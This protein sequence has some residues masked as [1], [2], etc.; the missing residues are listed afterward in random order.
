[1]SSYRQIINDEVFLCRLNVHKER[2]KKRSFEEQN[3]EFGL[4]DVYTISGNSYLG[5][6]PLWWKSELLNHLI[7]LGEY[8]TRIHRITVSTLKPMIHRWT[9]DDYRQKRCCVEDIGNVELLPSGKPKVYNQISFLVREIIDNETY[10]W[11][12]RDADIEDRFRSVC[13]WCYSYVNTVL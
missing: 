2:F 3:E 8:H 13:R 9:W 10:K 1:M 12:S 6:I 5:S 4:I 11:E 7:E